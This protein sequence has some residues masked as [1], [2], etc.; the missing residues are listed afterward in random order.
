[1]IWGKGGAKLPLSP[2]NT[3]PLHDSRCLERRQGQ[4]E[5]VRLRPLSSA[6]SE[7]TAVTANL[8][9]RRSAA[10]YD[11]LLLQAGGVLAEPT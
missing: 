11:P 6:T 3:L 2:K 4:G 7:V 9:S 5:R 1:M 8:S 10:S